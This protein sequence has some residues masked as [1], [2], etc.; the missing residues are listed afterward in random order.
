MRRV[1]VVGCSGAGKTTLAREL[2]RRLGADHVELDSIFHQPGWTPLPTDIF[3]ARL[4][5]RLRAP[6]WVVDGNYD[7][8]VQDLVLPLADTVVWLDLSRSRVMRRVIGRTLR[9]VGR[10]IELWNGNRERWRNLFDPR[11]EQNI[12]L[13][14]FT[15]H[16]RY[17]EKYARKSADPALAHLAWRRLRTPGEVSAFLEGVPV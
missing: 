8:S 16:G 4:A 14:A 13:W 12:I 11:P 9:R 5:A 10:G 6:A 17:R 1:A 2:A 3:R 7:S 15:R